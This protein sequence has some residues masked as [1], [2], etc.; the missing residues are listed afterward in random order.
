RAS[1]E[2][3]YLSD[4]QDRFV[5][6]EQGWGEM[7]I[8]TCAH[9][10][11][12]EPLPMQIGQKKYTHGIGTHANGT[13]EVDLSGEYEQ[14]DAEVGLQ[15][16]TTGR[17]SVTF[18]VFVDDQKQ[19]DSGLMRDDTPAKGVSVSL[20]GG[21]TLR[22]VVADAGDGINCDCANWAEARLT[23][24][25]GVARKPPAMFDVAPF[26][27][28]VTSDPGRNDGARSARTEEYRGEDVYLEWPIDSVNSRVKCIGLNWLERRP[29]R[30][31]GIVFRSA[32][33]STA[34]TALQAWVGQT[35]YQGNWKPVAGRIEVDGNRWRVALDQ[36]LAT[37][38]IRWILPQEASSLGVN[39]LV[40]ETRTALHLTDIRL[41][42]EARYQPLAKLSI[43]NGSFTKDPG[44][45]KVMVPNTL[46]VQSTISGR[47]K[48]QRTQL[49]FRFGD[50]GFSV[51][52]DD[53]L[54]RGPVYVADYGVFLATASSGMTLEKFKQQVAGRKTILRQVREMPDQTLGSA[55]AKLHHAAQEQSPVML[56]LACDNH[57]IIVERNGNIG[58]PTNPMKADDVALEPPKGIT[59]IGVKFGSG[60]Y[61]KLSRHLDGGW[62]PAP[63]LA[64]EA[65]GAT[66]REEAM[67]IPN[68]KGSPFA[69]I[70]F[71][72]KTTKDAPA[73]ITLSV[74]GATIDMREG[75]IKKDGKV[76]AHLIAAE[77]GATGKVVGE[78]LE[79]SAREGFAALVI[80]WGVGN[81][82]LDSSLKNPLNVL[83]AYWEKI[84][85]GA[86]QID[87][88]DPLLMNVIR[89][90]QIHCLMAA[91]SEEGGKLVQPW[92]SSINYGPLESEANSVIRGMDLLGHDDF[93]RKS[94]DYFI[95][96][97]APSGML[98]TGYTLM[99][100]GWHLQTLGQHYALYRDADWLKSVAP[101]VATA[102]QW[103][104]AQRRKTMQSPADEGKRIKFGLAP[105][106]VMADWG[107]YAYYFCLNGYYCAGL[108]EAGRALREINFAGASDL[109][110]DAEQYA[111][112]I[113]RAYR[114]TQALMPVYPLRDGTWVP[115]YP[116]QVD[117]PG[118]SNDFFPGEDGNRSWC[119]DVELG[120][121]QLIP[122]G[123]LDPKSLETRWM[124]NH[125]EDVQFLQN[126]WFDFP[127]DQNEKDPYTFG[128]FAKV[129]PYYCRNAEIDAMADDVKPFIRS[130]FNTL[131][132]LL[133]T[134]VLSLQEHFNSAGAW[135]KTH[136]TGYFLSQTRF[137]LVMEH[138]DSLWLAPS[139]TSNWMKDGMAVRVKNA[140]T[141]FGPVSYEIR[142]SI[143]QGT[144]EATID[145]P[146]RNP[147]KELVIRLR[148]P[149]GR[150]M[151]SVTVNGQDHTDFDPAA[152]TVRI[153]QPTD[154]LKVRVTF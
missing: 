148:D 8:N 100:T 7:G 154:P 84:L 76:L 63:I 75:E 135:N 44:E 29:M 4:L 129:Q 41:E 48:S 97:Y 147:P 106:G 120:A 133:N 61:T 105:P 28:L 31:L 43:Y 150:R 54:Q 27:E 18:Q 126:G 70:S 114:Q 20:K 137:M 67:V 144:I 57:K 6:S 68:E 119:Y 2:T 69:W 116:S 113:Q 153:A 3:D 13:I 109:V 42:I 89:A 10:A 40:A 87:V 14:F 79:L 47:W 16:L 108:R 59:R 25:T 141:T 151:K 23:R 98:T 46:G 53:I 117:A 90:S 58:I 132:T 115:G 62:L 11:G 92:I 52:V 138:G 37:Q 60:N 32:A 142:S 83:R 22:L 130:Y 123:V 21:R 82:E 118:P 49:R 72:W 1:A 131:P 93:A 30:E 35:A 88:A 86:T 85:A 111:Q 91:R 65:D 73:T 101:K 124:I 95:S 45:L 140:P 96:K 36:P 15:P 56:S 128:G 64:V 34:G 74:A 125:M 122:Q 94:F 39:H 66:F 149:Q 102:C 134:E 17:G 139:V 152:E 55:M 127:A 38:K 121:H 145:P 26:A 143:A 77:G 146:K 33:P 103:I 81:D 110:A 51:F 80:P 107:N 136:E 19:F 71:H 78:T 9:S 5:A 99:G 104:D 24:V 112:H 12:A 50:R